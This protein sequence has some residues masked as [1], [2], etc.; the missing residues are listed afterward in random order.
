MIE[1]F[2]NLIH[3]QR[4]NAFCLLKE[5]EFKIISFNESFHELLKKKYPNENILKNQNYFDLNYHYDIDLDKFK[6]QLKEKKEWEKTIYLTEDT[7]KAIPY[8]LKINSFSFEEKRYLIFEII[9]QQKRKIND[10][11]KELEIEILQHLQTQTKL[12]QTQEFIRSLID[13]SLDMIMASDISERI[14]QVSPSACNI[15]GYNRED[16]IGS[17]LDILYTSSSDYDFIKKELNS[18]GYYIGEVVNKRKNGDTFTSYLTASPIKNETGE[19]LGYMGISRDITEIKKAEI[20]LKQSEERYRLLVEDATDIIFKT[21]EKGYYKFVNNAFTKNIKYKNEEILSMNCMDLI[22]ENYKEKVRNF[23]LNQIEKKILVEQFELPVITKE[24]KIIWVNQLSRI[25][26]DDN[27]NIDGLTFTARDVTEKREAEIALKNSEERY[28]GLFYNLTDAI[29]LV[30]ENNDILDMNPASF[31]LL[32]LNKNN[33]QDI[34]LYDFISKEDVSIAKI[35][36]KELR[37]KGEVK[38]FEV[39]IIDAKGKHKIV[40]LSSNAVYVDGKFKGSRDILRDVTEKKKTNNELVQSL[41]EKEVLLKEVHHRVKNNLQVI[42]SILN[43]QSTYVEDEKTLSILRE[44]QNRV[45]SMSFIHESL[46]RTKD[47][48][49]IDFSEYIERLANNMVYSYQYSQNRIGLKLDIEEVFLSLDIS[50]P[51]GLIINELL[52]NALKYAFPENQKGE[53]YIS[54]KELNDSKIQIKVED[55]GVGFPEDLDINKVESLGMLLVNT[56][57]EQIDGDIEIRS[58]EGTKYLITF[59]R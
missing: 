14:T 59:D 21:D 47:F 3:K 24:K 55:N 52:S 15:F 33:N 26:K 37:K 35:K 8:K 9:N 36:S 40:E 53:I 51:C 17:K 28:R 16:L 50:I 48:N 39:N 11:I 1:E 31:R 38:D 54:V 2:F 57:V 34:N 29:I 4:K 18:K 45:K 46:Y 13:S 42:S 5:E 27:G 58:K 56:L 43:L 44:S 12:R 22:P 25:E 7:Q 20:A 6:K 10:A 41:K 23:Y 19:L 32:G 30:N 49:S